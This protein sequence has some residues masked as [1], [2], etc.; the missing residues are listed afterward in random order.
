MSNFTEFIKNMNEMQKQFSKSMAPVFEAAYQMSVGIS[1]QLSKIDFS[2]I[3]HTV[4]EI[5][6]AIREVAD[7]ITQ[8]QSIIIELGYPPHKDFPISMIREIVRDY[9]EY[10]KEFVAEYIDDMMSEYYDENYLHYVLST[11]E[12]IEI[13]QDRLPILRSVIKCHNLKMYEAAI[14]TLLPQLEGTLAKGFNHKGKLNGYQQTVYLRSLLV[15]P[16]EKEKL[17]IQFEQTLHNFYIQYILVGFKHGEEIISDVSRHAILHGGFVNY[18]T[19]GNSL[20][21]I[22]LFDYLL[23]CIREIS[24]E[25]IEKAKSEIQEE[26]K[27]VRQSKRLAKRSKKKSPK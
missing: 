12:K 25:T 16:F 21:L 9:N 4:S 6:E 2:Q 15:D 23:D 13:I 17:S 10:G 3:V 8:F 11:W 22:L 1:K 26:I 14:P 7:E 24:E 5:G 19:Q 20:K 27:K 18:A